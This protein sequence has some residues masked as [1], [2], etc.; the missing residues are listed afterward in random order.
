[1][2]RGM[3]RWL[4]GPINTACL[5]KGGFRYQYTSPP[6]NLPW[7][8]PQDSV[9]NT[10]ES[11]RN[12][13]NVIRNCWELLT[14]FR[15]KCSGPGKLIYSNPVAKTD[16]HMTRSIGTP[17]TL[18]YRGRGWQIVFAWYAN[19]KPAGKQVLVMNFSA[20]CSCCGSITRCKCLSSFL[21]PLFFHQVLLEIRPNSVVE[22]VY[23]YPEWSLDL[24]RLAFVHGILPSLKP[25]IFEI[26]STL[27][28][29]PC[30]LM[31]RV[32]WKLV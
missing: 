15:L 12:R 6:I 9:V 16:S 13:Q 32:Q 7:I 18:P 10:L 8:P 23:S 30:Q 29:N 21:L 25:R 27:Y 2:R 31:N 28:L 19:F 26:L 4:T 22:V 3:I 17:D 1:M 14:H 20:I 11:V 24:F 5:Y